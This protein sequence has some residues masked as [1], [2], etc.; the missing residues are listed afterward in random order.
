MSRLLTEGRKIADA[1]IASPALS[2]NGI[3]T[4]TCEPTGGCNADQSSFKGVFARNLAEL[5]AL[6]PGR[7]YRAYLDAQARSAYAHDRNSAD[8]YG[9]SWAGP[10]DSAAIGRQE[11][12]VSLLVSSSSDPSRNAA[13]LAEP[14]VAGRLPGPAAA[15]GGGPGNGSN[16][17]FVQLR[18][19]R[20]DPFQQLGIQHAPDPGRPPGHGEC[21]PTSWS[22]SERW[23][24]RLWRDWLPG[25]ALAWAWVG[26]LGDV[27]AQRG[28]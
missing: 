12:A 23:R 4:E 21:E 1:V 17:G 14:L 9:L 26:D 16:Q 13:K 27:R 15:V 18:A 20:G 10:F 24:N 28:G 7:P 6:L 22:W 19:P 5:N 25:C 3:L 11:S 8:Q 2:P